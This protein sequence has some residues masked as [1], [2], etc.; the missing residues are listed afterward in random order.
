MAENGGKMRKFSGGKVELLVL[1]NWSP[2]VMAENEGKMK[3]FR[4]SL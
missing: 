4:K 2:K 3:N 1:S